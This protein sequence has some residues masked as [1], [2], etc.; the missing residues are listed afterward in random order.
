M[1]HRDLLVTRIYL[2]AKSQTSALTHAA[3]SAAR[4]TS[5]SR[6]NRTL[7]R[8]RSLVRGSH[9]DVLSASRRSGFGRDSTCPVWALYVN[10]TPTQTV[11][12]AMSG[13]IVARQLADQV[14]DCECYGDVTAA[15]PIPGCA[16]FS[17]LDLRPQ[18][19]IQIVL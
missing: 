3:A 15:G 8:A 12:G 16:P 11:T 10:L 6:V 5:F 18:P 9:L 13:N 19:R 7:F 2:R 17:L 4:A 1:G 14:S